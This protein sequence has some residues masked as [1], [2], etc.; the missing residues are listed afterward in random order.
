MSFWIL[1]VLAVVQGLT[2]FLPVSSSGH[3][4]LLYNWFGIEDGSVL[5]SILLHIATLMSVLIYYRK[6]VIELVCHPFCNTNKKIIVTTIFT[7]MIV[8]L[9]KP[10]IDKAFSGEFLFVYFIITA[11]LLFVSD[12]LAEKRK[13]MSRTEMFVQKNIS[14]MEGSDIT[15]IAVSYK[16]AIIIGITQGFACIPGISRSGSTI[17]VGRMCGAEDNTRYS[18]LI[19][20]PIIVASFVM[21]LI[22]VDRILWSG[23]NVWALVLSL[24]LCFVVGLVCI[25]VMTKI[26]ANNRLT[27]FAYYLIALSTILVVLP[28]FR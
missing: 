28:F 5:L 1:I 18:F 19:S 11:I 12:Y 4:V 13:L 16:Q 26:V 22:S 9:I 3:L 6:E 8:L 15:N 24:I 21:E 27:I 25:K 14:R 17:A 10:F 23:I 2:E 7:C 20:I